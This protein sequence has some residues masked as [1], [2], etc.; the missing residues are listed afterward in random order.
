MD[1][2]FTKLYSYR[3]RENKGDLENFSTELFAHCLMD[4]VIFQ[5]SFMDFIGCDELID[6]ISTQQSYPKFGRPDIEINTETFI[7]LIENKVESTE[8]INQL[9]RY[10]N[11][12]EQSEKRKILI[13]LT[14]FY[15][16]KE[17]FSEKINFQNIKWWDISNLIDRD[18]NNIITNLFDEFL[19]E[20]RIAM[21]NN[22]EN[23]DIVSLENI[24]NVISKMDEVIDS[25]RD[26]FSARLG[27]FS[28]D[29]SRSTRLGD[30]AYYTYKSIGTPHK[31]NIDLGYYWWNDEPVQ[32]GVRIWI[33]FKMNEK[34]YITSFFRKNLDPLKWQEDSWG[35][36]IAFSNY[37]SLNK[38]IAL[39]DDQLPLMIKFLK[40]CIDE[41][42]RL[43]S[44]N[45][46]IFE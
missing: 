6:N 8:G 1:S 42:S 41:L 3:Q 31:F 36:N 26:Y 27:V 10:V 35:K 23:L 20:N 34:D 24:S 5:K 14:K 37:W 12:L 44:S 9:P 40:A 7:I 46:P 13:Y 29:S 25:V 19:L 43:K 39:E 15:E 17:I 21:D 4:D 18:E 45:S 16:Q 38:I 2:L 33:P 32:L 11:I 22:F 30:G 28:K